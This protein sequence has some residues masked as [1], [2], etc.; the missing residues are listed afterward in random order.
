MGYNN[1]EL[2][3]SETSKDIATKHYYTTK[4]IQ[5]NQFCIANTAANGGPVKLGLS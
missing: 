2:S 1:G 4:K 5:E 3:T